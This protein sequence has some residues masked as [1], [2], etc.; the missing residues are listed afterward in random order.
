MNYEKTGVFATER[1]KRNILLLNPFSRFNSFSNFNSK[2]IEL[3]GTVYQMAVEHGLPHIDNLYGFNFETGE[4]MQP[5]GG[6]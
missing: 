1:E 6:R 4:F 2:K 3:W 5:V